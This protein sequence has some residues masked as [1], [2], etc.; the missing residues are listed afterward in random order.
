MTKYILIL[1]LLLLV[2]PVLAGESN[3][4]VITDPNVTYT[5]IPTVLATEIPT[6]VPTGYI[7][8]T[9]PTEIPTTAPTAEPTPAGT[10]TATPGSGTLVFSCDP[11]AIYVNDSIICAS[12]TGTSRNA[13]TWYWGD[14]ETTYTTG[15]SSG[16]TYRTPGT[17][18]VVLRSAV[19]GSVAQIARKTDYISVSGTEPVEIPTTAEPTPEITVTP[20][21]EPTTIQPTAIPTTPSGEQR[22]ILELS[23]R[24][25]QLIREIFRLPAPAPAV[26]GQV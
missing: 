5:E 9:L 22:I 18:T 21:P 24:V 8:T 4:E 15:N 26:A 20:S 7:P 16:H 3:W 25:Y 11:Q 23:D 19:N 17:F 12:P 6:E 14:G 2:V 10:P 1:I 13:L